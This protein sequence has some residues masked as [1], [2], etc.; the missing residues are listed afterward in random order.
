MIDLSHEDGDAAE[1]ISRAT[2]IVW[3]FCC[4]ALPKEIIL[5]KIDNW[6]GFKWVEFFLYR[7]RK[8]GIPMDTLTL[9]RFTPNRIVWQHRY[10]RNEAGTY[11]LSD[12]GLPLH[13]ETTEEDLSRKAALLCPD[14]VIAWFSGNSG[15][16]DRGSLMVYSLVDETPKAWFV[17]IGKSD[18]WRVQNIRGLSTIELESFERKGNE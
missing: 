2:A 1:F 15:K 3:G 17:E 13:L 10:C 5:V 12:P 14:S 8:F 9:P 4:L 16:N 18:G 6:F 7:E 11:D